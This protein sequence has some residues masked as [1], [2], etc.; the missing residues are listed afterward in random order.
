MALAIDE[1]LRANSP[2]AFHLLALDLVWA[3][4]L[5]GPKLPVAEI[6]ISNAIWD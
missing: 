3:G 2:P 6:R 1:T 5:Q 4:S